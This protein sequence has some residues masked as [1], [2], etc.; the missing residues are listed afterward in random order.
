MR[1]S[2]DRMNELLGVVRQQL[3]MNPNA[4]IF[5]IQRAMELE[6]NRAFDKNFIARLK[7]K[8]HRERAVRV[9]KSIEY[10]LSCFEDLCNELCYSLWKIID[11]EKTSHRDA[12]FAT[13]VAF[14][15]KF[16]L[17][18]AKMN[19]GVFQKPTIGPREDRLSPEEEEKIKNA[20]NF[21]LNPDRPITRE[22]AEART[23]EE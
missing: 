15:I 7:N 3:V 20:I 17:L 14:S 18:E 2:K 21:A 10:E 11:D 16:S 13:K 9:H 1:V 6:Y 8:I 4:T 22:H 5:E 12:I 23:Q 19:A